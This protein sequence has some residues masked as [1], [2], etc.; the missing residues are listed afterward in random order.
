VNR[1]RTIAVTVIAGLVLVACGPAASGSESQAAHESQAAS[2]G[3]Q[4][5][6]GGVEPS[7]VEGAVADLEALIPD[8]VG[9]ITMA[10]SSAQGDAYLGSPDSRPEIIQFMQAVGVASTDVSIAIGSGFNADFT[11]GVYMFVIR[12]KGAES[13][14]LVSALK[15]TTDSN[16][17]SPIEWSHATIG[18]KQ[19]ETTGSDSGTSYLYAKGDVVFWIIGDP[20]S[21]GEV[22][23]GLP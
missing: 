6:G 17:E 8:T 11:M 10:K 7:F 19:V 13:S 12:A 20:T 4:T 16:V 21:A 14:R 18:G 15:A 5:P 2:Q 23:S 22:L 9:G 3:A 1:F